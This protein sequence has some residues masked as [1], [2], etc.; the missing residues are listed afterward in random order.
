M[1]K[2]DNLPPFLYGQVAVMS[3]SLRS[4]LQSCPFPAPPRA[5]R[6]KQQLATNVPGDASR[7]PDQTDKQA[8]HAHNK[9]QD[10]PDDK[11]RPVREP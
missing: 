3:L 9:V 10:H 8:D 6:A 7:K 2:G 5:I 4:S 1:G 11:T